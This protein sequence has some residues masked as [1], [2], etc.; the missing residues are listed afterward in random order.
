MRGRSLAVRLILVLSLAAA[1]L[2]HVWGK[3]AR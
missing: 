3:I 1:H 2:S